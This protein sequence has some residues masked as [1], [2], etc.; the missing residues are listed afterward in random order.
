MKKI[1]IS[2]KGNYSRVGKF[3]AQKFSYVMDQSE[4][5]NKILKDKPRKKIVEEDFLNKKDNES[6]DRSEDKD[7]IDIFDSEYQKRYYSLL[8]KQRSK[9]F[10][11]TK[12][13]CSKNKNSE[14]F[15]YENDEH[16]KKFRYHILHHTQLKKNKQMN[17]PSGIVSYLD[18]N[19][20][21][22]FL[23][24]KIAYSQ[25]FHKMIGR[26]DKEK[27]RKFIEKNLE[28]KNKKINSVI[29]EKKN[30]K[31]EPNENGN[32]N[33]NV[34]EE[35]VNKKKISKNLKKFIKSY[36]GVGMDKQLQRGSLPSHHDVRIRT[37]KSPDTNIKN[38]N[39]LKR[40][41]S[42]GVSSLFYI[43]KNNNNMRIFSSTT[44]M[45]KTNLL[46]NNE[47]NT[48]INNLENRLFSGT[49]NI[50][51]NSINN[52]AKSSSIIKNNNIINS[53]KR[54]TQF[55]SDKNS[56][57]NNRT[58]SSGFKKISQNIYSDKSNSY[59]L[60]YKSNNINFHN[61]NSNII[62]PRKSNRKHSFSST[63]KNKA[64]SF[65]K[66]LSRQYVNG[67]KHKDKIDAEFAL[68]PKYSLVYPK[69][70]TNVMYKI[71]NNY[72][73]KT[74]F[75]GLV[76]E[77]LCANNPKKNTNQSI[78]NF[79]KMFGRG[80][81][82]ES[83]Y[84]IFMNNLSSRNIFDMYTDK[85][86]KMNYFSNGKLNN[87]FSS[88]NNKKSFNN[89]ISQKD[90]NNKNRS[91]SSNIKGKNNKENRLNNY[92]KNIENIFKKVVYDNI[93][94]ENKDKKKEELFDLTKNPR[95]AKKID[96][97]YKN[98][99]SDYYKLNFDFLEENNKDKIDGVTF[100]VIKNDK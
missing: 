48:P 13:S 78:A 54:E 91:K 90:I 49:Q 76:G 70:V 68:T 99:I 44:P 98:L 72:I 22:D 40:D 32:A 18:Q 50:K 24:N 17:E 10:I 75:K 27:I 33:I 20:N 64:I 61:S 47:G 25:S 94:D 60:I 43:N 85:S 12:S 92:N 100:K 63:T 62:F 97:S 59:S 11:Y 31:V 16:N 52:R 26:N 21:N 45:N 53:G 73:K 28:E 79:A 4:R 7:S 86:L 19:L 6:L 89:I 9:Y 42:S 69:V 93:V 29:E 35:N 8:E 87:P 77:Q 39:K 96:L 36:K 88:F 83:K 46:K 41:I 1:K 57:N 34:N 38:C 15:D 81:E 23:Y 84:P 37:A 30:D 56:I 82:I 74:E 2:I 67:L 3:S 80:Q 66:M 5:L 71:K 14:Y 55:N 95:L 58:F 51:N 65:K